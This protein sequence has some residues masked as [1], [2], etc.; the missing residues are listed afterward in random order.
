[1]KEYVR[2]NFIF[3]FL[4]GGLYSGELGNKIPEKKIPRK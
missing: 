2:E 3:S 4:K 1:M